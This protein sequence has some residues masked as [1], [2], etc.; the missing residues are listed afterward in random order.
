MLLLYLLLLSLKSKPC[1]IRILRMTRRYNLENQ[2]RDMS[3][4]VKIEE[5]QDIPGNRDR[6]G[7]QHSNVSSSFSSLNSE[8]ASE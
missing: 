3:W 2:L 6:Q 5:L 7:R 4:M 1:I 8:R